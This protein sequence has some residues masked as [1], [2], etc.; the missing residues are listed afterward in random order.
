M[1]IYTINS[2]QGAEHEFIFTFAHAFDTLLKHILQW[3]FDR[4]QTNV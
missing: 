1:Q 4:F 2:L 3:G